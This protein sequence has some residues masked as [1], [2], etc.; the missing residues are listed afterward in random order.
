MEE[1][2]DEEEQEQEDGDGGMESPTLTEQSV[3][4]AWSPTSP[5]PFPSFVSRKNSAS[6]QHDGDNSSSRSVRQP[7]L[8]S[9]AFQ[10]PAAPCQ[11]ST[12]DVLEWPIASATKG[13]FT[14]LRHRISKW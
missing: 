3:S 7:D 6:Q 14:L 10:M 9:P 5:L 8:S 1:E 2:E 11:E 4:Q 13:A 12:E